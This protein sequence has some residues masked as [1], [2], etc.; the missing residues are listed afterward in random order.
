MIRSLLTGTRLNKVTEV[1]HNS[2]DSVALQVCCVKV[3]FLIKYLSDFCI[4]TG[5]V[6]LYR[7]SSIVGQ[8]FLHKSPSFGRKYFKFYKS[9]KSFLFVV[10][11]KTL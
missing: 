2:T 1:L 10:L 11:C 3:N 5:K 8:I 9:L 4:V 6:Y 7:E